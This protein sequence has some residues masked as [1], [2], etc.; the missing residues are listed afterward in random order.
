MKASIAVLIPCYDEAVTIGRVVREFR[1]ELP[2]ARILVFDNNSTD[3]TVQQALAHGAEV[4]HEYKRGK[5]NVVRTMFREV[6]ADVYVMVDGDGTYPADQVHSLL[7]PV[8]AGKADMV[9]GSRLGQYSD[10]AFRFLHHF[11]NRMIRS[12]INTLFGSRLRDVLSGYRCFSSRFVQSV[13]VLSTGFEVETELTLHALDKGFAVREIP[14]RYLARPAG[15]TSKLNTLRDGLLVVKTVLSIF[16][17]Y[18]PLRF[19]SAIGLACG[20]LGLLIGS[21]PVREFL[22]SGVVSHPSTAVLATGLMLI[23]GLSV[24]TGLIL[25]TINR[26]YREQHQLLSD[27]VISRVGVPRRRGGRT[28]SLGRGRPKGGASRSGSAAEG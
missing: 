4:S 18:R 16:K 1:R 26:R 14:V 13:P 19:F 11:G 12:L 25:D 9:V 28:Q 23:S 15:S 10:G 3:A 27:F 7:A 5:G 17:D 2:E 22:D 8:L 24:M 20:L 21:I 6:E